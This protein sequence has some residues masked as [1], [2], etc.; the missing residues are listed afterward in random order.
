MLWTVVGKQRRE[1]GGTWENRLIAS[2]GGTAGKKQFFFSIA[3]CERNRRQIMRVPSI[4]YG[5]VVSWYVFLR[6]L[7]FSLPSR[8]V[9]SLPLPHRLLV[10]PGRYGDFILSTHAAR[11][12]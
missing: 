2:S 11:I 4:I 6:F 8:A 7:P 9:P 1:G 12:E 3:I 10:W 5:E